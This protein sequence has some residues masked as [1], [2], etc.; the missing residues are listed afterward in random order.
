MYALVENFEAYP[1]FLPW[2]IGATLHSRNDAVL[3]ASL[4]MQRGGIRKSFRTRNTLHSGHAMSITLMDGPFKHLAGD[5]RFEQLGNDGS[6]VALE[7]EFEFE[8]RAMDALFGRYF[9]GT[10]NSLIDSFTR[11]AD[12]I[13]GMQR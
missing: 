13:Y 1:D 11:R 12:K 7:L 6:K 8:N 9:E 5:W 4:E 10:C 3:E 2:C